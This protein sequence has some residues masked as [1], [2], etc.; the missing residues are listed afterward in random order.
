MKNVF[1]H[2][3]ATPMSGDPYPAFISVNEAE[4]GLE[5]SV[6]SYQKPDASLICLTPEQARALADALVA[7]AKP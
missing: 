1:A 2:T 6:R 5:F 7:W 3:G 4:G